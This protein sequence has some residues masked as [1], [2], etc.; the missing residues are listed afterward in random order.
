[1]VLVVHTVVHLSWV[2]RGTWVHALLFELGRFNIDFS[3]QDIGVLH[4]FDQILGNFLVLKNDKAESPG[5]AS[6]N[7]FKYD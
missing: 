4:F 3:A 1:M 2:A 6:V 7:V 5:L